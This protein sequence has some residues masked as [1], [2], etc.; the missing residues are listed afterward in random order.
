[1]RLTK[2]VPTI[3]AGAI[4]LAHFFSVSARAVSSAVPLTSITDPTTS[5]SITPGITT[6]GSTIS[7]GDGVPAVAFA[8][9]QA[10]GANAAAIQWGG[11]SP[12]L[13]SLIA[14][15]GI[16][17]TGNGGG[18]KTSDHV[19]LG[20]KGVANCE[21]GTDG[22]PA[23]AV[24]LLLGRLGTDGLCSLSGTGAQCGPSAGPDNKSVEYPITPPTS[25]PAGCTSL[26][27]SSTPSSVTFKALANGV[28][29]L[30]TAAAH[31]LSVGQ[32]VTVSINDP[33]FDGTHTVTAVTATTFSYS[34]AHVRTVTNKQVASGA[35]ILTASTPHNLKVGNSVTV[36][37]GD[38]RFD[39]THT[40]TA[41]TATTFSYTPA[42]IAVSSWSVTSNTATLTA[43][44]P[45]HGLQQGNAVNV[46]GFTNPRTYLNGS[47]TITGANANTF[48]Y[49]LV[50]AN[51]NGT[52][53]GTVTVQTVA[54]QASTGSATL[55]SE[56]QTAAIG[57]ATGTPQS[58]T[59]SSGWDSTHPPGIYCIPGDST[60][61]TL[62]TISMNGANLSGY[63]FYAPR[64]SV[65]SQDL[66][67]TN[68][69]PAAGQ[70]PTTLDAYGTDPSPSTCNLAGSPTSCALSITGNG[71]TISG[72]IFAPIGTVWLAGGLA[73]T[74]NS[75]GFVEALT[76]IVSGNYAQFK[77][78]GPYLGG[79]YSVVPGI[80]TAGSTSTTTT[81]G[82]TTT[83]GTTIGLSE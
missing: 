26:I 27:T 56:S 25:P 62:L 11:S 21:L 44:T 71:N 67:L 64:I 77:G 16:Y 45:P 73:S 9:S 81:P 51:A 58:V 50:H 2:A 34:V 42:T 69:P 15:G 7:N 37:I 40:I 35:A 39:G 22:F 83:V 30:T 76:L 48:S 24:T 32:S 65:S 82:T 12:V 3:I 46:A 5:T 53:T 33:V 1:V 41:V 68:A 23:G 70:P 13:G 59:L 52:N 4:G 75:G 10:C 63:T 8:K 20:K 61:T 31:N 60:S 78:N 66:T 72:D 6:D 57:T 38:P 28:A 29:T 54:S 43:T 80:T 47:Y 14:N 17:A 79:T 55:V 19:A 74:G 36:N 49:A 18:T